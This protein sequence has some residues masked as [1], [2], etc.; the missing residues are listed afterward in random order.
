MAQEYSCLFRIDLRQSVEEQ[1]NLRIGVCKRS[2]ASVERAQDKKG[3]NNG[4]KE[5]GRVSCI[6]NS[7]SSARGVSN[8]H[9]RDYAF[10]EIK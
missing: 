4:K 5:S 7:G 6:N 8:R 1:G 2:P 9:V 3:G 10:R